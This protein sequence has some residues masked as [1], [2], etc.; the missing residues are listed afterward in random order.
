M[1]IAR[2]KAHAQRW[3]SG[4]FKSIPIKKKLIPDHIKLILLE[5]STQTSDL[6]V[7]YASFSMDIIETTL[8]PRL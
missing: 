1:R 4:Y 8:I 6:S 5:I 7:T 3:W 2:R